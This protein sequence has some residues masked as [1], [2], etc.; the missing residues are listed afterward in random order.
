MIDAT[1]AIIPRRQAT[2][3]TPQENSEADGV[4]ARPL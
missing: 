4:M 2:T 3:I 1:P